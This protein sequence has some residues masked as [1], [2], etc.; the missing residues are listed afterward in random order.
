MNYDQLA[1]HRTVLLDLYTPLHAALDKEGKRVAED[2]ERE[3]KKS[4]RKS[5]CSP[6]W[7]K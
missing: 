6:L 3:K 4:Q 1:T 5:F 7:G 2:L